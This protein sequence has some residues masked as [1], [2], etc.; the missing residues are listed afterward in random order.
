[1]QRAAGAAGR[2]QDGDLGERQGGSS[3]TRATMPA[4][5]VS[6]KGAPEGML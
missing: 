6:T 3:P 4:A 5:S 1:M 2:Q